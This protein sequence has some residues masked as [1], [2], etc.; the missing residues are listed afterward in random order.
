MML[1]LALEAKK[2][3]H[4]IAGVERLGQLIEGV[5]FVDEVAQLAAQSNDLEQPR[6][7]RPSP[8]TSRHD[9]ELVV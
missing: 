7:T 5:N 4:R 1:Q 9:R 3:W 8:V 2:H 6:V